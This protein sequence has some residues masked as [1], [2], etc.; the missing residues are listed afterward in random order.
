MMN[1]KGALSIL[2]WTVLLS[3]Y[4]VMAAAQDSPPPDFAIKSVRVEP[5]EIYANSTA[6]IFVEV[7]N[8]GALRVENAQVVINFSKLFDA[9]STMASLKPGERIVLA[10]TRHDLEPGNYEIKATLLLGGSAYG[11]EV[12]QA[13]NEKT[14][15]VQVRAGRAPGTNADLAVTNVKVWGTGNAYQ[16][17]ATVRNVGLDPASCAS[18]V[19]L[20]TEVTKGHRQVMKQEDVAILAGRS[21]AAGAAKTLGP[22]LIVDKDHP[23][24]LE[25]G[26]YNVTIGVH[27][28]G[29]TNFDDLSVDNNIYRGTFTVADRPAGVPVTIEV[30]TGSGVP[31]GLVPDA[32]FTANPLEVAAGG[33]VTLK[34]SFPDAAQAALLVD[35]MTIQLALPSGEIRVKPSCDLGSAASC[36]ATYRIAGKT[37]SHE[38]FE[39]ELKIKVKK[40]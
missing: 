13:N 16:A 27:N 37:K 5:A 33:E 29:G 24:T 4:P 8:S 23:K 35:G 32:D 2:L 36:T 10:S 1:A 17:V 31:S 22:V 20:V 15:T 18:D 39:R 19:F 9:V 14:V 28:A 3:A 40:R 7:E 21:F 30:K 34:W 25:R 12:N 6:K 38:K 11:L 26:T